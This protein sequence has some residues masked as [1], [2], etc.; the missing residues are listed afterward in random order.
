MVSEG[1]IKSVRKPKSVSTTLSKTD[2]IKG[3]TTAGSNLKNTLIII[4]IIMILAG[5]GFAGYVIYKR[6]KSIER[7]VNN[8]SKLIGQQSSEQEST[9]TTED[10][11][12]PVDDS[13]DEPFI[14]SFTEPLPEPVIE[15]L[16]E[17]VIELAD[18]PVVVVEA[19]PEPRRTRGRRATKKTSISLDP[20][21]DQSTDGIDTLAPPGDL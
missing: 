11:N 15:L 7:E 10:S 3:V 12:T 16:D 18:E 1:E 19:E 21:Q 6:L 5:Y 2:M 13:G 20:V 9:E 17:R 14:E 8:A 4:G